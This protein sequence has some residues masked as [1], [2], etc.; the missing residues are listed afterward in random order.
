MLKT[1]TEQVMVIEDDRA[2]RELLRDELSDAGYS[3]I[4]VPSAEDAWR[5]LQHSAIALIVSD[6]RLPRADGMELLRW[7]EGLTNAP[8]FI[9]VTAFG[10]IGQAG[11]AIKQGADDFLAKPIDLQHL[12]VRVERVLETRRLRHRIK[13]LE[14]LVGSDS[15]HGMIARSRPIRSIFEAVRRIGPGDGSLLIIG[16]SG[17][18]KELVARAVHAES[19]RAENPFIAVNCAG[20]PADLLESEFFGHIRGA[21]TGAHQP[22]R[23]LLRQANGGTLFLDEIGEMPPALQA[24]LLRVLEDGS[25]RP[26]GADTTEQVDVRVIAATNRDLMDAIDSGEFRADLYY[27]LETFQIRI[28][29]LRERGEDIELLA[30]RFLNHFA[31][32]LERP[33][34]TIDPSALRA[35]T[36][37]RFPGNVRELANIIE[38]AVTFCQ[39]NT[40]HEGDLPDRVRERTVRALPPEV[41]ANG[42]VMS[43]EEIEGRYISYVLERCAG[44]KRQAAKLLGV[45][46]RTLYR[47]LADARTFEP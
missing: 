7:L 47:K 8:A 42:E 2:L 15:F 16:E 6:L 29:P 35:L 3:V 30:M 17:T 20:V 38:R 21:F 1:K 27:R 23:G 12:L 11:E 39:S 14:S 18:G 19:R 43:L 37:Y 45:G 4:T 10:T 33:V 9:V 13:Q 40:V 46:R 31:E 26:V 36:G 44:N 22:R 34:Q 25:V 24:K 32:R 41:I 5:E 28:P